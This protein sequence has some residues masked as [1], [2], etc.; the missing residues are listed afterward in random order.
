[1]P[2]A[3]NA[4]AS[5]S[6]RKRRLER[7][8]GFMGARSK[9]FRTATESVNKALVHAYCDRRK[10]KREMRALWT[11]RINAACRSHGLSYCRFISGL[12]KADV[13][14]DRKVLADLAVHDPEGFGQLVERARSAIAG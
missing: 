6:R 4:P 11:V 9:L 14:L 1:M 7:A 5:R 2:R 10:R 13:G 12:E 3:T 8:K